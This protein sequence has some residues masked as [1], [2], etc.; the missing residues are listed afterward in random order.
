MQFSV[1]AILSL[2]AMVIAAP[3]QIAGMYTAIWGAIC[4]DGFAVRQVSIEAPAMTDA[5]GNIIP[6]NSAG[7]VKSKLH[8]SALHETRSWCYFSG[9]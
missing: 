2:A 4:T 5:N 1:F 8:M 9:G 7:V 6:F 3:T